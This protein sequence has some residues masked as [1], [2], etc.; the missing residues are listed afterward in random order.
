MLRLSILAVVLAAPLDPP[1]LPKE[2]AGAWV[3]QRTENNGVVTTANEGDPKSRLTFS[4]PNKGLFQAGDVKIELTVKVNTA[5]KPALIDVTILGPD[6]KQTLEGI[7]KVEGDTLTICLCPP[8]KK[9]RP[10]EF[11]AGDGTGLLLFTFKRDK[12]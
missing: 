7:W 10:T 4:E 1:K 5:M 3:L 2:L 6:N 8:D 11:Q 12:E 9:E